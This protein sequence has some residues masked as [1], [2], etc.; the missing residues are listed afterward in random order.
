MIELLPEQIEAVRQLKRA[1]HEA[2]VDAV[3]IGATAYQGGAR[4][5]LL[6][7]GEPVRRAGSRILPSYESVARNRPVA[8]L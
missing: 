8:G 2:G 6:P 7:I 5:D 1:C 4:I 3:I